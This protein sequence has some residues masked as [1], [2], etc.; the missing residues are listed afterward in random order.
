MKSTLT[1][2]YSTILYLFSILSSPIISQTDLSQYNN[3]A[4]SDQELLK[5]TKKLVEQQKYEEAA[6]NYKELLTRDQN[7][8]DY[9]LA[10]GLLNVR[11]GQRKEA[12]ELYTKALKIDPDNQQVEVA[13]A[14]AYF[15]E[16][17]LPKSEFYFKKVIEK[18]PDNPDALAGIGYIA[19]LEGKEEKAEQFFYRALK[20]NP[21]HTTAR[22]YLGNLRL[23][24]HRIAKAKEIFEKLNSED[25]NNQDVQQ[26]LFDVK[27]AEKKALATDAKEKIQTAP[28]AAPAIASKTEDQLVKEAAQL[29]EQK[30]YKKA[31]EIYE[32]L[33][34]ANPQNVD[35]QLS[36]G[37]LYSSLDRKSE[38]IHLYERALSLDPKRQ[39]VR[40]SLAYTYLF[41]NQLDN[42]KKLF[43][44]VLE[45]EP[46]NAEAL[47][48]LGNIAA[49]KAEL[50]ESEQY[51]QKAIQIDPINITALIYLA[52]LK[53]RR[54]DYF[55][56]YEI[57]E[58]ITQIDPG[59]LD[60]IQGLDNV[61]KRMAD[62]QEKR[63]VDKAKQLVKEKR[64]EEAKD[65]YINL[66]NLSPKNV[67]YLAE[68][69][70]IYKLQGDKMGAVQLLNKA[71]E[72]DP[73][74]QDIRITVAFAYLFDNKLDLS[75]ELFQDVLAKESNNSDALAGIGRIAAIQ[76]RPEEAQ[77][78]YQKALEFNPNNATALEFLAILKL[79]QKKFKEAFVI[80]SKLLSIDPKNVD[81]NE[82]FH[83]AQEQPLVEKARK[84]REG[85]NNAGAV[86]LLEHLLTLSPEK[87]E[88]YLMLGPLYVNMNR[89]NDAI[90]LYN[91]GLLIK[92]N[93]KD[94]LRALGFIYLNKA[95]DDAAKGVFR[96]SSCFPFIHLREKTNLYIS[97]NKFEKALEQDPQDA[98][99]LAGI[100]RIALIEGVVEESEELYFESLTIEPKNTTAL[101]YL[102]ALQTLQ[103]KYYT[104]DN[105][106]QFLMQINPKDEE[107]KKN[108]KEFLHTKKASVDV[109]DYYEKEKEKDQ[110]TQQWDALLKNYGK[111]FTIIFPIKD[112][113]KVVGNIAY[114]FIVLKNLLTVAPGASSSI[115]SLDIQRPKL[116]VMWNYSPY[117]SLAA[118][119]S[120][121]VFSQYRRSTYIT[122]NG[123]YYLPFFNISYVKNFHTCTLETLGDAPIVARNFV[124]TK[125]TLIARQFVNG[126]YEYDLTKRRTIGAA[127]AYARYYNSIQDNEFRFCSAWLQLTPPRYWENISLRYQFNYGRFSGLTVDYYTYRP[128]ISHWAKVDLTKK[129]CND[130]IVTEAGYAHCWQRSFE[131]GQII[132]VVPTATFHWI[133]RQ[134]DAA[135]G[136]LKFIFDD[137]LN[138]AI[139]GTYSHD[140]FDYTTASISAN[141]HIEF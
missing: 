35:Y 17:D 101:S 66:I 49:K 94:L 86:A 97:K 36:L 60:A 56:A 50:E 33:V 110:I 115:Y 135:Y 57:Y 103:R 9:L 23:R 58:K 119:M 15:F 116:G 40:V 90:D 67:D 62:E 28:P 127:A 111:A 30:E 31:A 63:L 1:Y 124:T 113:F 46:D 136:R 43:H 81:Y 70:Q 98:S 76:K 133:N 137:S 84:L 121:A 74:R 42:S 79:Q 123:C 44:I 24:Q 128:Q 22:I 65:I 80:Y 26:A 6:S 25:P 16:G 45:Q 27:Y 37:R 54:K 130:H 104:A 75:K 21:K 61:Q 96:W 82:G 3:V 13:L 48:G 138:A 64:Y 59:N 77:Q 72:L 71:L 99:A 106:Y 29:R 100:G 41:E 12:V 125:A 20:N 134:I 19:M 7:N 118:G 78:Y 102:A 5:E 53:M 83:T 88:Y 38:A 92:P 107:V 55:E 52:D 140:N 132:S 18:S 4:E 114:D 120:F 126:F 68:L 32:G 10:L 2:V 95:L 91:Q 93:D 89:K 117:L 85:K 109:S 8:V 108:Y 122:K 14:F 131:N 87:I 105:T 112:Q 69:A 51:L 129:W 141:V 34:T 11:L 73:N 47:A 39:D 139:V